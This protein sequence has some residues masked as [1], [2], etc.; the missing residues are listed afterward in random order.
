[1][2]PLVPNAALTTIQND[3][4][5]A[6]ADY[7][8]LADAAS[9]TMRRR[10]CDQVVDRAAL[11]I[12]VK[13]ALASHY[14]LKEALFAGRKI[15][16][17]L[18]SLHTGYKPATQA[19]ADV[20][21]ACQFYET[22]RDARKAAK[23]LKADH[24][25]AEK[26]AAED[27]A[28]A[29]AAASEAA[30]AKA[31]KA[32]KG[33]KGKS[34][35]VKSAPIVVDSDDDMSG[36]E[37]RVSD[38]VRPTSPSAD[39]SFNAIQMDVDTEVSVTGGVLGTMKFTK[40]KLAAGGDKASDSTPSSAFR[41]EK[42]PAD[43]TAHGPH[44]GCTHT[45]SGTP[46]S[47]TTKNKPVTRSETVRIPYEGNRFL[48]KSAPSY[49]KAR[50][51][52]AKSAP[53]EYPR[54]RARAGSVYRYD[55]KV[56]YDVFG[57]PATSTSSRIPDV[58][59]Y[60]LIDAAN[61]VESNEYHRVDFSTFAR[62]ER[63]LKNDLS[64]AGYRIKH[65]LDLR[66][67]LKQ[68]MHKLHNEYYTATGDHRA[69]EDAD[70]TVP[71]LALYLQLF[72]GSLGTAFSLVF[73]PTWSTDMPR[74]NDHE[75]FTLY[76]LEDLRLQHFAPQPVDNCENCV[77]FG[78]ECQIYS[79]GR[80]CHECERRLDDTCYLMDINEWDRVYQNQLSTQDFVPLSFGRDSLS[81]PSAGHIL[82]VVKCQYI[83]RLAEITDIQYVYNIAGLWTL[84]GYSPRALRL[85]YDRLAELGVT[86]ATH[87]LVLTLRP[88]LSRIILATTT[89][90][91]FI[92]KPSRPIFRIAFVSFNVDRYFSPNPTVLATLA[93]S[94]FR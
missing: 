28:A 36:E 76:M 72:K 71:D 86:D 30:P 25:L 14:A 51:V 19:W 68:E 3:L 67:H 94:R 9:D 29:E 81:V 54:K 48:D 73:L 75:W 49:K 46:A 21:N 82:N 63:E 22:V 39:K 87:S 65:L 26:Q 31:G 40:T 24:R 64:L 91:E 32:S 59:E 43:N 89:S 16:G 66:A 15:I 33:G 17:N 34:K 18:I 10:Q 11:C 57:D 13:E 84:A 5:E 83:Q 8:T 58:E 37:K 56:E 52:L 70:D 41:T 47:A 1:M 42:C 4:L 20:N 85:A 50:Q 79:F 7:N 38:A 23:Q 80:A 53:E 45:S 69:P 90:P 35:A 93:L 74:L 77:E 6:I 61:V 12:T 60:V 88:D 92:S 2:P 44:P 62:R 27:A 55:D 78:R